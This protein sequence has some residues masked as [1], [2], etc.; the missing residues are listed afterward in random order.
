MN[1]EAFSRL[2]NVS[3]TPVEYGGLAW[4]AEDDEKLVNSWNSNPQ[5]QKWR[6]INHLE[7]AVVGFE[8]LPHRQF[9]ARFY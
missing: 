3:K 2:Q 9:P 1:E 5:H 6:A 7:S 8:S 4:T